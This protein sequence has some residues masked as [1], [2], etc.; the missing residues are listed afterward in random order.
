[1]QE[2]EET[3]EV[4]EDSEQQ[5]PVRLGAPI[6]PYGISVST[7]YSK[8]EIMISHG[9]TV[10]SVTTKI[11]TKNKHKSK[12]LSRNSIKNFNKGGCIKLFQPQQLQCN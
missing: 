4:V 7:K 11:E 12:K 5:P 10:N 2:E 6:H 1:M 3:E 9:Y 8:C